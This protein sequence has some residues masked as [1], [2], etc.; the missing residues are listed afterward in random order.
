M[1]MIVL[2]NVIYSEFHN[3]GKSAAASLPGG[4][5]GLRY[6]Y[7]FYLRKNHTIANNSATAEAKEKIWG[8]SEFLEF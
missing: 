8:N 6:A 7:N 3:W 1:L 4:D 5:V 2:M